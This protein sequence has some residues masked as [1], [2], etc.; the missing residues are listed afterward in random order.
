MKIL[1]V[2]NGLGGG[3]AE[4]F[5]INTVYALEENN[6]EIDFLIRSDINNIYMD[7]VINRNSK[8]F[9]APSFPRNFICNYLYM[10]KFFESKNFNYDVIHIHANALVYMLPLRLSIKKDVKVILHSHNTQSKSKLSL[11]I[12]KLNK[13]NLDETRIISLACS[14]DAGKWMFNKEY[15]VVNNGI[16]LKKFVYNNEKRQDLREKL[17]VSDMDVVIGNVGRLTNQKNHFFLIDIFKKI[18]ATNNNYKLLLVGNGELENSIKEYIDDERLNNNIIMTGAI[19]DVQ[20]MYQV[21]DVFVLTSLYEG[22]PVALIEAQAAG[23]DSVVSIEAVGSEADLI[24]KMHY[25]SLNE[26]HEKWSEKI[27]EVATNKSRNVDINIIENKGYGLV[28]L[29]EQL[30]LIYSK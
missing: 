2:L 7:E 6:V 19:T 16:N 29:K 30:A 27:I 25:L 12:H 1:H 14:D 23:L 10:K 3:G 28:R 9:I 5:A 8:V 15:E 17:N 22:L 18:L 24:G 20:D 4:A 11:L 26:N 21:M 13:K